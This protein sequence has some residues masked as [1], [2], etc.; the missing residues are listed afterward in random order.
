MGNKLMDT[1]YMTA[2]SILHSSL[3][4]DHIE[5]YVDQIG[6]DLLSDLPCDVTLVNFEEDAELWMKP[7]VYAIQNQ[8]QPFVH[9]D[10]DIFLKENIAFEFDKVL[11]E[12]KDIGFHNYKELVLFFDTYNKDLK[13]WNN[14]LRY[15]WGCGIL[16]FKDLDIRDDFVQSFNELEHILTIN[17]AAF[18]NFKNSRD[19]QGWYIEPG[20]LLEQYNLASLL[21]VKKIEPTV[22]INGE[23]HEEQSSYANDLGYAHLFGASKYHPKNVSKIKELLKDK[24]FTEYK[25]IEERMAFA[26]PALF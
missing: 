22:L 23:S 17:K 3:W 19:Q 6:Y 21:A 8:N 10:T 2:A 11:V 20:L 13:F 12:R 7:K 1:I 25:Q 5:L 4:Y 18:K 14:E 24:F 16:G 15:A 26:E 9:V